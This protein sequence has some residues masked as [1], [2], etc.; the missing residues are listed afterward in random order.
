MA[1]LPR[2]NGKELAKKERFGD[3][4]RGIFKKK[5]LTVLAAGNLSGCR[6]LFTLISLEIPVS[7]KVS[8]S[9][10]TSNR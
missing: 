4:Q 5:E 9:G 3:D 6:N 10:Q 7:A 2:L 1:K 8:I